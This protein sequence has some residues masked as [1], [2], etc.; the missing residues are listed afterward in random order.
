MNKIHENNNKFLLALKNKQYDL[1]NDLILDGIPNLIFNDL[2][3]WS[4]HGA[5]LNRRCV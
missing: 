5:S 4:R 2:N 3:L 1:A